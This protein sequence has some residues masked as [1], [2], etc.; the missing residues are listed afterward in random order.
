MSENIIINGVTMTEEQRLNEL[1]RLKSSYAMYERAKKEM[2][3]KRTNLTDQYGN[4]KY[5]PS[6]VDSTLDIMNNMQEDIISQY[7]L[8]GGD[9]SDLSNED[10]EYSTYQVEEEKKK[11]SVLW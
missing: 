1:K 11:C 5:T 8:Y 7:T 3:D 9:P 4:N 10:C 2:I 6:S